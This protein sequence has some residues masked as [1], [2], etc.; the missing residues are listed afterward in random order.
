MEVSTL[1]ALVALVVAI[2]LI[3]KKV[4]PTVCWQVPW[5]AAL[6]AGLISPVRSV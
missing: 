3:L 1:G 4:P 2:G 5:W 6:S